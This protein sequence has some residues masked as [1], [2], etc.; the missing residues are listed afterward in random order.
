LAPRIR[1]GGDLALGRRSTRDRQRTG[2]A[3]Q[4]T[5]R[6]FPLVTLELGHSPQVMRD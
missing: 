6:V 3:V 5:V 4:R 2:N 1:K